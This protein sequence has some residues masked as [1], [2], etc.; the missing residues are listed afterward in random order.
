MSK[1]EKKI[2]SEI[3]LYIRGGKPL[4][5]PFKVETIV[6]K[7]S[8][9]EEEFDFG[10]VTTLGNSSFLKMTLLNQSPIQATLFLDLREKIDGPKELEGIECLDIMPF[11]EE[12]NDDSSCL[13]SVGDEEE[14]DDLSKIIII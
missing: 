4:S 11:N 7:V 9:L 13:I 8:V 3:T 12:E 10:G 5:I 14:I 2:E 1:E 6:P